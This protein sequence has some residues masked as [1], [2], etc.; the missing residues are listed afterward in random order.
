MSFDR[1]E[2]KRDPHR[3][4]PHQRRGLS[5]SR[6]A[7]SSHLASGYGNG[8]RARNNVEHRRRLLGMRDQCGDVI[9]AGIS[10]NLVVDLYAVEANADIHVH[11]KNAAQIHA[12][13]A[14]GLDRSKLNAVVLRNGGDA[15]CSAARTPP[16]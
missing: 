3:S 2:V 15:H 10:V 7:Q 4:R 5:N 8:R 14:R 12:G 9:L 6:S 1:I 11:T 16:A 13:F